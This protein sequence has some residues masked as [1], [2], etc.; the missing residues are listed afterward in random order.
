MYTYKLMHFGNK[1][2]KM[3][4]YHYLFRAM[5]NPKKKIVISKW[6]HSPQLCWKY[7]VPLEAMNFTSYQENLEVKI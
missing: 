6:H 7:K 3:P 4:K 2:L 5:L 1:E